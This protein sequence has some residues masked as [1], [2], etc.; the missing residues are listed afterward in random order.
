VVLDGGGGVRLFVGGIGEAALTLTG[1]FGWRNWRSTHPVMI[2]RRCRGRVR[3]CSLRRRCCYG[4]RSWG[5][6]GRGR[7]IWECCTG[8]RMPDASPVTS[9]AV[10]LLRH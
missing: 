9:G 10:V 1:V 3:W 6:R 5:I 4:H 2:R 8:K 7:C